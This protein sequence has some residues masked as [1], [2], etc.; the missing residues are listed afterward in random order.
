[1]PFTRSLV[2]AVTTR[3]DGPYNE[4]QGANGFTFLSIWKLST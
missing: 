1:V 2:G 4:H 3:T